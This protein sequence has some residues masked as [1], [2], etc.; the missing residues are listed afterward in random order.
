[1]EQDTSVIRLACFFHNW[2]VS[3]IS[4]YPLVED[5]VYTLLCLKKL[6]P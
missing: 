5:I 3:G 4:I 2:F 6:N 1:M